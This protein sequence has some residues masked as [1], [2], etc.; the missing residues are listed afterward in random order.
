M[1][2]VFKADA[3]QRITTA[4]Y[5]KFPLSC[6]LVMEDRDFFYFPA[7]WT[8]N[9]CNIALFDHNLTHFHFAPLTI[10]SAVLHEKNLTVSVSGPL[11]LHLSFLYVTASGDES[12]YGQ[13]DPRA[14]P[15]GRQYE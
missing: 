12:V 9:N 6:F 4:S 14:F 15:V 3:E 5:L 13:N 2:P 10:L 8:G 1:C 11:A 7:G